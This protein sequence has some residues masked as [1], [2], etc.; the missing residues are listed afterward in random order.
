MAPVIAANNMYKSHVYEAFIFF[1]NNA[2]HRLFPAPMKNCSDVPIQN[3]TPL[4]M[5]FDS[6]KMPIPFLFWQIH[7]KKLYL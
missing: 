4:I 1:A 5:L 3:K 2:K 7:H 6:F